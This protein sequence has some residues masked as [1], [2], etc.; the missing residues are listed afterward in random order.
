MLE[1]AAA[2]IE[3]EHGQILIA[4][5]KKGK[6]QEGMWEFPG[7]KIEAGET[8]EQCLIREL[9]EEMSIDIEPYQFFAASE[10]VDGSLHIL[11]KAYKAKYVGGTIVL[12]DHDSYQWVELEQLPEF[13][14]SP[15]DISFVQQLAEVHEFPVHRANIHRR[16]V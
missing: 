13:S 3:N 6:A 12:S 2:I 14:F 10:H 16:K 11:L 7:G 15:A 5:R 8:A 1:V 9:R 4:R